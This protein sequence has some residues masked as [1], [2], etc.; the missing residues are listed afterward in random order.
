VKPVHA[1]ETH[2]VTD[3]T[4]QCDLQHV[5]RQVASKN[6]TLTLGARLEV[7]VDYYYYYY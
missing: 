7:S 3:M 5:T 4:K 2:A 6:S 1:S